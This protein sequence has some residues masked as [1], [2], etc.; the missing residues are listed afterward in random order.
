MIP[1]WN[2]ASNQ[3]FDNI[4][5]HI[6]KDRMDLPWSQTHSPQ[7]GPNSIGPMLYPEQNTF[8]SQPRSMHLLDTLF[9]F[10]LGGNLSILPLQLFLYPLCFSPI[11]FIF[12]STTSSSSHQLF[13]VVSCSYHINKSSLGL[14]GALQAKL[15]KLISKVLNSSYSHSQNQEH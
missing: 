14:L 13:P 2:P 10:P 3:P 11:F 12:L 5:S 15:F 8:S 9:T 4:I 6:M 7:Q 1:D